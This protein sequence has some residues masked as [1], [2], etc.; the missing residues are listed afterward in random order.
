MGQNESQLWAEIKAIYGL[1]CQQ[2]AI[3]IWATWP[4]AEMN[5]QLIV[6]YSCIV[7]SCLEQASYPPKVAG[8]P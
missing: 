5:T 7:T 2:R 4:H 6:A 1:K 3:I 8:G